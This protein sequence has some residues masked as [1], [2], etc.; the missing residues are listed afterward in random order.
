L[1][2]AEIKF[3][4]G[5]GFGRPFVRGLNGPEILGALPNKRHAPAS[6]LG[7]GGPLFD[8][9]CGFHVA[10]MLHMEPPRNKSPGARPR[11]E[12]NQ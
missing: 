9:L 11:Q 7:G 8:F 3:S 10:F 6:Q 12:E 1:V 5:G 2:V 4:H